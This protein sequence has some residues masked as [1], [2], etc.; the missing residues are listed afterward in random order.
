MGILYVKE[1]AAEEDNPP[2]RLKNNRFVKMFEPLTGMY[3]MPGYTEYDPTPVVSVFF[4][5]FF[6]M[7]IKAVGYTK[8]FGIK[9][10]ISTWGWL[11]LIVG[12][13]LRNRLFLCKF[14]IIALSL[15]DRTMISGWKQYS[16][17]I[18]ST[19]VD[20]DAERDIIKF[21][22]VSR[23]NSHFSGQRISFQVI[24]LRSGI[25]TELLR[26]EEREE[27]ILDVCFNSIDSSRPFFIGL[28]G[29][30]YGWI[31]PKDKH[32]YIIDRLP[33]NKKSLLEG[34][35]D[36]SVT[37]MEILYGA[38]GNNGE[39][40]DHSLFFYRSPESYKGI[41][42][43]EEKPFYDYEN[44][45]RSES[46][47]RKR[48]K[49]HKRIREVVDDHASA[50]Q[51]IEYTVHFNPAK[52]TFDGLEDFGELVFRRLVE[53]VEKDNKVAGDGYL[54]WWKQ[55][56]E[57]SG[58]IA[59][60]ICSGTLDRT[61][62]YSYKGSPVFITGGQATGKTTLLSQIYAGTKKEKHIAYVS[63][64]PHSLKMRT[65]IARW[66][67]EMGQTQW[68]EQMPQ[69]ISASDIELFQ[70]FQKVAAD[71][72]AVFFIDNIDGLSGND[73]LLGWLL[74]SM[75][76]VISG[77]EKAYCNLNA[78]H[79]FVDRLEVPYLSYS[80]KSSLIASTEAQYWFELPSEIKS[81]LL[82]RDTTPGEIALTMKLLTSLSSDDFRKIRQWGQ[83][84][85]DIE[86]INRYLNNLYL[87]AQSEGRN[88]L[89]STMV[90]HAENILNCPDIVKAFSY[91]AV[92][93]TGL[94]EMD[95]ENIMGKRWD[96]VAFAG[97]T[98]NFSDVLIMNPFTRKWTFRSTTYASQLAALCDL[99]SA[100]NDISTCLAGYPDTDSVKRETGI[101]FFIKAHCPDICREYLCTRKHFK[102]SDDISEW[103]HLTMSFT[104]SDPQWDEN[105]ISCCSKMDDGEKAIFLSNY[106]YHSVNSTSAKL[107]D[108][109]QKRTIRA[110]T[111]CL[112]EFSSENLDASQAF[113]AGWLFADA[114][115]YMCCAKGGADMPTRAGLI[116]KAAECFEKAVESDP[117]DMK[118]RSMA[119][120]M[121]AEL[122]DIYI[123]L[124]DFDK[125]TALY[126]KQ[127]KSIG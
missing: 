114:Q 93:R 22:V 5:L 56:M 122:M 53:I 9:E 110:V 48:E 54:C 106:L 77:S 10:N 100:Y 11:I 52:G 121:T 76:V 15:T 62:L 3:G 28:L 107:S 127:M 120:A 21:Q 123:S 45:I 47:A 79:G 37:E 36:A 42:K 80:E 92:S 13:F 7:I 51:W 115:K 6:A 33:G 29:E 64:T 83:A 24:D 65:I 59:D 46:A 44:G 49:L 30:R 61:S 57:T 16:I 99:P 1:D 18:S 75:N 26:K 17:F 58:Y 34:S 95:L 87:S 85:G 124:G 63:M 23:L 40:I 119:T 39:H 109:R 82:Q 8:R 70:R 66:L 108:S 32:Q 86:D 113:A 50:S 101:Y 25:N 38:I 103:Y 31:P 27:R 72:D 81:S 35:E 43:D 111:S 78:T 125:V 74:S 117:S 126:E 96:P 112:K 71:R 116:E 73:R 89:G 104:E 14:A 55:E 118:S 12:G 20:M 84:K 98:G 60:K 69:S 94:R 19:F 2:I 97:M 68:D 41:G 102:S 67:C 90:R 4:L 91:I 88:L 105:I